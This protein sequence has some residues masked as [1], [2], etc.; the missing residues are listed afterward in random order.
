MLLLCTHTNT[1]GTQSLPN[2]KNKPLAFTRGLFITGHHIKRQHI[3]SPLA[4][5]DACG[6]VG[7]I[8]HDCNVHSQS[9][10]LY[11][12]VM[13][14]GQ[15]CSTEAFPLYYSTSKLSK[16]YVLRST[17]YIIQVQNP[18]FQGPSTNPAWAQNSI[19][20]FQYF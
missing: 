18:I 15:Y 11:L 9:E 19:E 13:I 4:H 6:L 8:C 1:H 14:S 17:I 2:I 10:I 5:K 20:Y 7:G 3:F 12:S 16:K